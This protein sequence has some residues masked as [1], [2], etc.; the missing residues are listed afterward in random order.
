MQRGLRASVA[1]DEP[2]PLRAGSGTQK[3]TQTIVRFGPF[4][5]NLASETLCR[6]GHRVRIQQ[7]PFRVLASLLERPGEVVTRDELSRRLRPTAERLDVE[8]SL[9]TA[10]RKVRAALRDSPA[11]PRYVETVR[12]RGYRF[13]APV[14]VTERRL[15]GLGQP[16]PSPVGRTRALP[17]FVSALLV[18]AMVMVVLA[19]G[20]CRQ[21]SP[22]TV[23]QARPQITDESPASE[24]RQ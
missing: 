22:D 15:A 4:E 5:V 19:L 6:R 14:T 24:G 18:V 20:L 23:S 8:R 13:L 21:P 3:R 10:L 9:N 16:C 7:Q 12:G 1:V 17:I 2:S 11:L